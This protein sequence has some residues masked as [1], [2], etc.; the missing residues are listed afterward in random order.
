MTAR[1]PS[2]QSGSVAVAA[3]V[4]LPILLGFTALAVDG[5]SW[6]TTRQSMQGAADMAAFSAAIAYGASANITT[7]AKSVSAAG[8]YVDG[9][10]GV[11]VTVAQPPTSGVT[12]AEL[13]RSRSR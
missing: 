1:L 10:N 11:V 3:A 4:I 9:Q 7:E 12:P 8:G 5:S 6:L 2:D 13:R